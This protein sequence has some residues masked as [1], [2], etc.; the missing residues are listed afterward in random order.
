MTTGRLCAGRVLPMAEQ[1]ITTTSQ[2]LVPIACRPLTEKTS[3]LLRPPR[4]PAREPP[5]RR[6]LWCREPAGP[7]QHRHAPARDETEPIAGSALLERDPPPAGEWNA[8]SL[9]V[10]E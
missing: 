4:P 6:T 5:G 9:P 3:A 7:V 2:D 1:A 8:P 10:P